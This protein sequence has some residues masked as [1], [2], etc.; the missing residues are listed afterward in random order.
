MSTSRL[1]AHMNTHFEFNLNQIFDFSKLGKYICFVVSD[2]V[3]I[4]RVGGVARLNCS[5]TNGDSVE[6]KRI[7]PK[8]SP[9]TLGFI[10]VDSYLL[11][12]YEGG[13]RHNVSLDPQTGA[14][15]LVITNVTESDA[16]IY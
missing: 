7:L 3:V 13:G 5:S 1:P 2:E 10:Y 14:Y 12:T 9:I 6:W 4:S 8:E 16:G 15:D 11:G